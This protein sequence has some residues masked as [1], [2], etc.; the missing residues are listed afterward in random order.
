MVGCQRIIGVIN[1][2]LHIESNSD[3]TFFGVQAEA[4]A[5]AEAGQGMALTKVARVR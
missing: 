5:E 4:E 1:I 2:S 3:R